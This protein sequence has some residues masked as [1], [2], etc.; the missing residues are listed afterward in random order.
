M[1]LKQLTHSILFFLFVLTSQAALADKAV[2]IKHNELNLNANL[3]LADGKSLKDGIILMT[4]G[5]LA[6]GKMEIMATLQ[7]LF[8]ENEMSSLAITLGLNQDNR[9]GFYDCNTPHTHKHTDAIDEIDLWMN[10]LKKQGV[11]NVILLGYSR[12]GNQ[13]A[14]YA[15]EH[16]SD[17]IK[18]IILI[19]PQTWNY[20]ETKSNYKEKYNKELVHILN[21]ARAL[22]NQGR[23]E[24]LLKHTDFVYCKDATVSA[25]SFV[26]YYKDDRRMDTPFIISEF[27]KP[28]L[29]FIGSEDTVFK[30]LAESIQYLSSKDNIEGHTIDGAGHFFR[31]L[32]ADE[33]VEKAIEFIEQ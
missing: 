13:T 27:T 21:K 23:P 15:A 7:N 18:K 8:A 29:V 6:H 22:V 26:S 16:D 20:P 25:G 1:K 31:D 30:G 19:A 5:T 2:S 10:W 4:H 11:T 28:T 9:S 32:Y 24:A 3:K 14:W 33:I 17:M 12:G